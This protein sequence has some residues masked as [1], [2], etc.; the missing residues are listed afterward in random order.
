MICFLSA[1]T[2]YQI[3]TLFRNVNYIN[4]KTFRYFVKIMLFLKRLIIIPFESRIFIF[5]KKFILRLL[6]TCMFLMNLII[7]DFSFVIFPFI[8]KKSV[9]HLFVKC[10]LK[11]ISRK[12]IINLCLFMIKKGINR[13][14]NNLSFIFI[15]HFIFKQSDLKGAFL[16][17][18]KSS[19][20]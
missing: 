10:R 12:M 11:P 14:K 2:I 5:I 20:K 1:R 8:K 7:I 17:K 4:I 3:R 15:K 18:L 13:F 19:I 16:E 6:I 9:I